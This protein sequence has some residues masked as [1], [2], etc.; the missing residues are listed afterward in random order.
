MKF[1]IG[2]KPTI[3][4]GYGTTRDAKERFRSSYRGMC[5]CCSSRFGT[6]WVD[7]LRHG[8]EKYVFAYNIEVFKRGKYRHN[9]HYVVYRYTFPIKIFNLLNIEISQGSRT[10]K[11]VP[12]KR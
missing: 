8:E 6:A 3:L 4:T 1:T 9:K 10:F 12:K 7:G 5:L 2:I 11:I